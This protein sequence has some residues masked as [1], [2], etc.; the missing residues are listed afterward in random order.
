MQLA[1][2]N[3]IRICMHVHVSDIGAPAEGCGGLLAGC[4]W[5]VHTSDVVVDWQWDI[6]FACIGCGVACDVCAC[7]ARVLCKSGCCGS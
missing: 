7:A 1:Y 6:Y 2:A 3:V 5:V 4:G